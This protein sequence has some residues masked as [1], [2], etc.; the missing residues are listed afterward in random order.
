MR[1]GR[2]IIDTVI[3]EKV[4]H[5]YKAFGPTALVFLVAVRD[6]HHAL[7]KSQS[8]RRPSKS[9]PVTSGLNKWTDLILLRNTMPSVKPMVGTK[10]PPKTAI[11]LGSCK[12]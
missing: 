9:R 1:K 5:M 7:L 6:M 2:G 12:K 11:G 8:D 10:I 4:S 3:W